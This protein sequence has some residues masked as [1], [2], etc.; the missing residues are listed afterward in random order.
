MFRC[1]VYKVAVTGIDRY[2]T[3][4][5]KLPRATNAPLVPE[6]SEKRNSG[7]GIIAVFVTTVRVTVVPRSVFATL[8][9][10]NS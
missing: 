4:G 2:K 3:E 8:G 6:H 10:A 1:D 7:Q 9:A 5:T